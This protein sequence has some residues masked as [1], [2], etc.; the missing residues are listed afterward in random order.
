MA[1]AEL[2][3]VERQ[4]CHF[5]WFNHGYADFG[6]FLARFQSR[7]R[8]NLRREREKVTAQE[9]QVERRLDF[10]T[11]V[12][13]LDYTKRWGKLSLTPQYKFMLLRLTDQERDVDL[14]S[15]HRSMAS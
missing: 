1:L 9:V 6:D 8:K 12:S 13:R 2:P 10:W 14:L 11:W 4:A 7:K 5:R 15:E 3:L